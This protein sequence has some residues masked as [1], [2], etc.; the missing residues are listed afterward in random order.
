M[1]SVR[2]LTVSGRVENR[3]PC[4][5]PERTNP[6]ASAKSCRM[7]GFRHAQE[8]APEKGDLGRPAAAAAELQEGRHLVS[9][10]CRAPAGF[11]RGR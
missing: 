11:P 6:A 2:R 4:T 5:S 3:M 1:S 10:G 9:E 8:I 7:L